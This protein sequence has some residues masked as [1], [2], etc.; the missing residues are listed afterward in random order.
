MKMMVCESLPEPVT[1]L[2]FSPDGR[3]LLVRH[4][5]AAC[6]LDAATGRQLAAPGRQ[7]KN[8]SALAASVTLDRFVV[9]FE[10]GSIALYDGEGSLL[11][12]IKGAHDGRVG[13]ADFL[14]DGSRCLT[15]CENE[16][17]V[18]VRD[19]T[20]GEPL[21]R[22]PP[23]ETRLT[24]AAVSPDGSLVMTA[25]D[26]GSVMIHAVADG[27]VVNRLWQAGKVYA[28]GFHPSLPLCWTAAQDG[29][30]I[31]WNF[32]EE[33][34]LA[35]LF[36]D[37]ESDRPG[38]SAD[39]R[40]FAGYTAQMETWAGIWDGQT[41]RLL[42]RIEDGQSAVCDLA[43][44]P[45]GS[46]LAVVGRDGAV[47]LHDA[48]DPGFVRLLSPGSE[49][50]RRANRGQCLCWSADGS[51]LATSGHDRKIR[52]WSGSDGCPLAQLACR[53]PPSGLVF[54][55]DGRNLFTGDMSGTVLCHALDGI[56]A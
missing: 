41:G 52:L 54:T 35:V 27:Q 7:R 38:F 44:A 12:Q 51:L 21:V 42:R 31:L 9:G 47:S 48:A 3:R 20:S 10:D 23:Q 53:I 56:D 1:G 33:K 5:G 49:A 55:P 40:F 11:R 36:E 26:D 2:L 43:F 46:R 4:A 22:L 50:A 28:A 32:Q 15:G 39:G 6:L 18:I 29:S 17:T 24:C 25:A 8:V 34:E 37:V 14:P 19:A 13:L 45:S 16:R 30:T